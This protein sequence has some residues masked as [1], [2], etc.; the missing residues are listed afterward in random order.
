MSKTDPT[1]QGK[2][3]RKPMETS[4]A[5]AAVAR[6]DLKDSTDRQFVVALARGLDILKA[7]RPREG[8]LGNRELSERTGMPAATVSRLAYT[9]C[10]L[11]YL[12]FNPRQE[13]YELGSSTLA[14]GQV[15][16]ARR[17]IRKVAAPLM[18][19]LADST[20]GNV[21]LGILHKRMMLYI[22]TCEGSGLIGLRLFNGSRIPV[23]TTAMGRAYLACMEEAER[24]SLLEELRPQFGADW[25]TVLVGVQKAMRDMER[26]GFCTSLGEWQSYIHGAGT[27]LRL[28]DGSLYGMNLGGAAYLLPER[29]LT[30]VYG[31]QLVEVAE[32]IR[33][34]MSVP[35]EA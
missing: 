6:D 34:A 3:R 33:K 14:L 16:M 13:N 1:V 25:P 28:S 17:N 32:K 5:G 31:P 11:G 23:A 7:F 24:A 12:E 8:P 10:R 27:A 19:Q 35:D 20:N 4:S 2:R 15:A 21:G 18:Q 26:D 30:E 29:E 9:L 22:E